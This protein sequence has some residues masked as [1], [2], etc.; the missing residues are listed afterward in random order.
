MRLRMGGE[1]ESG[2]QGGRPG[3]LYIVL[4]VGEHPVFRRD[5][6]DLAIEVPVPISTAAL[7]GAIQV[8]TL[9]GSTRVD[10]P[11]GTQ[12]GAVFCLRGKGVPRPDGG[13]RGDLYVSAL[14]E[15]PTRLTRRQREAFE[16]LREVEE[17]SEPAARRRD[18]DLMD[19]VKDIFS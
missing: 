6:A 17:P 18:K 5:G 15:V 3:D 1:G 13:A 19:R 4:Q 7:G 11:A 12:P 8:P 2:P 14:V 9:E 10:V 16:R